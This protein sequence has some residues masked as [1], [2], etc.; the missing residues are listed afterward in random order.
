M[1]LVKQ[2]PIVPP[3]QI[4]EIMYA[5]WPAQ[6]LKAA[7]QHHLFE[8]ID[9][10]AKEAGEV[11]R[12]LKLDVRGTQ[13]LLDAMVSLGFVSKSVD[14]AN[15]V[16][17]YQIAKT[18]VGEQARTYLIAKSPLYMGPWFAQ[19]DELGKM[20]R[21]LPDCIKS[22]KAVMEVNKDL[23]AEEI[24]PK[25]AEAIFPNSYAT[26]RQV[27]TLLKTDKIKTEWLVLDLAAGSAV[28]SIPFA[29]AS[30]KVKVDA[31]DFDAV[32]KVT[33]HFTNKFAVQDRYAFITG[34]WRDVQL[35]EN[36]YDIV[37]LGHILHSEGRDVSKALLKRCFDV[38]KPGGR[39][40]VA[41]MI[42]NDDRS[43]PVFPIMFALNMFL[44]TTEGCV[45]TESE[46]KDLVE[47]AGFK[48][49]YRLAP[50]H[51]VVIAE[52]P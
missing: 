23:Q 30:P 15:K 21:N 43:G 38:M 3:T 40:V 41:E 42:S 10:D 24:F 12:E 1:T 16:F 33:K 11:A 27:A 9:K 5:M 28:W 8:A 49:P 34:N 36:T 44:A 18:E 25:L 26:A 32:L 17:K 51:V 52:K 46:L 39:L 13:L 45:F 6:A 4:N 22:G 2:K 48:K 7:T 35:K 31:L 19:G 50:D 29:E 20:W 47:E 14:S 37:I